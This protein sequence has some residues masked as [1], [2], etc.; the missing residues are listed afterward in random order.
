MPP[1]AQELPP[2]AAHRAIRVVSSNIVSRR[3]GR[4]ET[5]SDTHR[6]RAPTGTPRTDRKPP[7]LAMP[8][9]QPAPD[10]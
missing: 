8:G 9:K 2:T 5:A 4:A 3:R 7:I 10:C 6:P 1:I